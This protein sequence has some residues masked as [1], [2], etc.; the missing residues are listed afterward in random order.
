MS[1]DR[2][3]RV[4]EIYHAALDRPEP[5]RAAFVAA[6][7]GEDEALAREVRSLLD[8]DGRADAFLDGSALEDEARGLSV[9]PQLLGE[10]DIDGYEILSLEGVGGMGEVYRARELALGREV[11]IKVLARAAAGRAGDLRRFEAEARLASGLNHPN[12]VTIYRVGATADLAYIAMELVRGRTLRQMLAGGALPVPEALDLGVQL[13]DALAAAHAAG[14]VHRDLKPENLMVTPEGLLKVLDFGIAKRGDSQEAGAAATGVLPPG[15]SMTEDGTILGT[16]GYMSPEQA[17]GRLVEPASDQFAFG[18]ILY[19][20][21]AGRRAFQRSTRA[22]TLDAI[23]QDEPEPAGGRE[24]AV[25]AP[26]HRLLARC[27]AKSPADRFPKTSDLAIELRRIRDERESATRPTRRRAIW[28]AT[29]LIVAAA[30]GAGV[31][32]WK[33]RSGD[34]GLRSIAVLP[35]VNDT[36]RAAA[37][38]ISDGMTKGLIR[39]ISRLSP[40]EVKAHSAV[41]HFQGKG[42]DPRD[43][44]RRLAAD[45]VVTGVV[46]GRSGR[47]HVAAELVEV[48]TG[49]RLWSRAWDG[50]EKDVLSIQEEIA[51]AVVSDGI[52]LPLSADDRRVLLRKPTDDPEAY[53]LY[54][55]AIRS[56]ERETEEEYLVA[57]DL[58]RRAIAKDP[59]F[60]LAYVALATTYSIMAIDGYEKPAD[61]LPEVSRNV[62]RAL[63]CD[64][65]LPDAHSEAAVALFYLQWDWNESEREWSLALQSRGGGILPNLLTAYALQE[66]ALGRPGKALELARRA[67]ALDPL[68][69]R[70]MVI[71]ADY[72]FHAG[73][74]D[75][76][77]KLYESVTRMPQGAS[78]EGQAQIVSNAWLGLAEVRRAQGRFDE[79][80]DARRR[81]DESP[82]DPGLRRAYATGRGAAGYR[83]IEA[84][85]ARLQ[86]DALE[87]RS[88]DGAYVSPLDFART[89]AQLGERER[90]FAMLEAAFADRSPGMTFLNVDRAWDAIRDDPRFPAFVRRVGLPRQ[91]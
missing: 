85:A 13:A 31:A 61:A 91:S 34:S 7:C 11:A 76:A 55:R 32:V 78:G 41:L 54:L 86:L 90:A 33:A 73:Q 52:R 5:E 66:W 4:E 20:M 71:E 51:R 58:L 48:A 29:A 6:A 35:F 68:S 81:G 26:L 24:A 15:P 56:T 17:A 2:W 72:L 37:G 59:N 25:K 9:E 79:A 50:D 83:D 75:E 88:R 38:Y 27:L 39:G 74:L 47:I 69:P 3:L 49:D 87:Q 43:A 18:A 64:P 57:R 14:T 82:E 21:L 28:L 89:Y 53:D 23:L 44:G 65:E 8:Y 80:I 1:S 19:E 22:A 12:I 60:A 63:D 70:L 46:T 36:G 42:V 40:L 30:V 67:R 62:R 77:A 16:V 10:H 45:A 84:V